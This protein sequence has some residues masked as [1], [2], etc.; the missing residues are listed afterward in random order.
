MA[1]TEKDDGLAV[2]HPVPGVFQAKFEDAGLEFWFSNVTEVNCPDCG[3]IFT[4]NKMLSMQA[5]EQAVCWCTCGAVFLHHDQTGATIP[6]ANHLTWVGLADSEKFS[7]DSTHR[8]EV[9]HLRTLLRTQEDHALSFDGGLSHLYYMPDYGHWVVDYA[10]HRPHHYRTF[11]EAWEDYRR[12]IN[13]GV[14]MQPI[15]DIGPIDGEPP[16]EAVKCTTA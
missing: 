1:D 11:E 5:D 7:R 4:E 10:H 12:F 14:I 16:A 9:P 15:D 3:R 6:L 13:R 8:D 2:D